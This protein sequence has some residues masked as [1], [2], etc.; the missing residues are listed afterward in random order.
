MLVLTSK[1]YESGPE[2]GPRWWVA[3]H[4]TGEDW[5][6]KQIC[7]SD[8]NYDTGCLHVHGD[9]W[10]LIAPTQQGPQPY[11]PGG[12]VALWRSE[13]AGE[14]WTMVRQLTEGSEY[15][16]TYVRRPVNAHPD[17][18]GIWADGHARRPSDSRIYFCDL[19]GE[20]VWRL[21]P[22]WTATARVRSRSVAT[23]EAGRDMAASQASPNPL[24]RRGQWRRRTALSGLPQP[25]GPE[26]VNR[27]RRRRFRPPGLRPGEGR[28]RR[29]DA[30]AL[31]PPSHL[32]PGG[33]NGGGRTR[34]ALRPPSP[35]VPEKVDGGGR[36]RPALRPP[37][38]PP[39]RR[40]VNNGDGHFYFARSR[41]VI[42]GLSPARV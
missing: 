36:T 14:S 34:P 16:H 20:H 28:R 1:G 11:N 33:D 18:A 9:T 24:R 37:P 13:D 25:S 4:W 26:K 32:R 6:L 23:E 15:N 22:P 31:R 19:S 39:S 5:R 21:R 27:G 42:A 12:E 38:A 8:S 40:K 17:F 35:S 3:A 29:K 10:T 41:P 2:N 7:T 30:A